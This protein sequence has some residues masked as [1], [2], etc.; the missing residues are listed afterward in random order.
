MNWNTKQGFTQTYTRTSCLREATSCNSTT[1]PLTTSS[2]S[3]GTTEH[4]VYYDVSNNVCSSK[5]YRYKIKKCDSWYHQ[6]WNS[7][8]SNSKSVACTKSWAPNNA[9]YN[10]YNVTV[11]WNGSTW[12][13]AANCSW[14]CNT[15]YH[16]DWN[17][18][19]SNSKSVACTKSWAPNNASYN[20]YNVTV[21]WNGSTWNKAANCSWYCNTDYHQE[22]SSCVKDA[23]AKECTYKQQGSCYRES[24]NF[25]GE[26]LAPD[27]P[28]LECFIEWEMAYKCFSSSNCNRFY[29]YKCECL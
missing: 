12:N 19:V 14:Y 23:P 3:N 26:A 5:Q 15:D 17:S 13:K 9:S 8:V 1:Y 29:T 10:S 16:Q 4:C 7:C 28:S 11:T 21:T 2:I 27:S 20:S 6:D 24:C 18:C 22:W 25:N